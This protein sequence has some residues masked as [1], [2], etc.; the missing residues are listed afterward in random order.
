MKEVFQLEDN[1]FGVKHLENGKFKDIE[2]YE[3]KIL[4]I[5]GTVVIPHILKLFNLGVK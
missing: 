2:E 5:E 1:D 4:K 3:A